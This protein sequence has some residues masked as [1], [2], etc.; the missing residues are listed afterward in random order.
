VAVIEFLVHGRPVPQGSKR[1]F[2]SRGAGAPRVRLVEQSHKALMPWRQEVAAVARR[3]MRGAEPWQGPVSLDIR[4]LLAGPRVRPKRIQCHTTKPDAD[5]LVRAIFDALRGV[6][7]L[8]DRQVDRVRVG[9][10]FSPWEG[11]EIRVRTRPLS[12]PAPIFWGDQPFGGE[13][14]S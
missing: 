12:I 1:A 7:Y 5:K 4:F 10:E 14:A 8:D 6:V 9:K 11:A 3:A 13:G 2:V